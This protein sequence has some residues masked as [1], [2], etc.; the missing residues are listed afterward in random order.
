MNRGREG[1]VGNMSRDIVEA[2]AA[3]VQ[4]EEKFPFPLTAVD[5]YNL[6][7]K[8]DDFEPHTWNELKQIIGTV[9]SVTGSMEAR[10]IVLSRQQARD[11]SK[12]A[13]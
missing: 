8:D 4:D 6:S 5:R 2:E 1:Q 9:I 10:L 3:E 7:L 12:M 13:I 11:T